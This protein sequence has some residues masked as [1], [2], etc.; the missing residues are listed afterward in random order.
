MGEG[1]YINMELLVLN[2]KESNSFII[3]DIQCVYIEP[4][5]YVYPTDKDVFIKFI[6]VD[7]VRMIDTMNVDLSITLAVKHIRV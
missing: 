4:I 5:A 2:C 7:L 1:H 6:L 3:L